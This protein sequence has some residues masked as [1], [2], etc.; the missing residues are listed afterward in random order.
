MFWK[1][2]YIWNEEEIIELGIGFA[3]IKSKNYR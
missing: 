3:E 2:G 1:P